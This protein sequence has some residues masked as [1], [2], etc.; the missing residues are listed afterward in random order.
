V[1]GCAAAGRLR[2]LSFPGKVAVDPAGR[3][4][5][6]ADT[7]NG[8]VVVC[9]L[10]GRVEQVY[11]LLT[12]P[13]GVRFDGERLVVCDTGADRVVA[14]DR[15]SGQQSV[16]AD[17]LAS[18]WDVTV[19]ADR[20]L[21]VA[22]AGRHRLW[23]IPAGGGAPVVVAGTGQEAMVDGG[24][25]M[26]A[27]PSGVGAVAGGGAVFV[28]AESSSLRVLAPDGA[29]TTLVGQGLWDWGASDGGP[30]A[31]A[32]QHPLGVA[33]G[34]GSVFVAD[35]YNHAV[36][37]WRGSAWSPE[38]GELRTL[39]V[40]GL[41]EPGGIDVLPDGRLVV[42][43]TNHHRVV[44]I[45]DG[46][47]R[48]VP[49][50]ESWLGT[51]VG[52][53]ATAVAGEALRVPFSLDPGRWALDASAG[54]PVHVAVSAEPPSL[55]GPGARRWALAATAGAVEVEAGQPGGG[56]L[57]VEVEAAVCDEE[58]R[59]VLRVRTR[60]DVTVQAPLRAAAER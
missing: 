12:R 43:D 17:G 32:L 23:R 28:D 29:V 6:V 25:A 39:P 55:L 48:A 1:W 52:P 20:S 38:A 14:I 8:R 21:L 3:R 47:V 58:Q 16:L 34:T 41:G 60:H 26:L 31:A 56:M 37:E 54:P 5:A 51:I 49:V 42:A 11:P 22:E 24:G 9:D 40:S 30:E 7:G 53:P 35:T 10:D 18:P 46:E 36:R 45:D 2:T 33:V 57:V 27:Q 50:D 4:L 44:V 59:T 19:L 13:Q 15:A